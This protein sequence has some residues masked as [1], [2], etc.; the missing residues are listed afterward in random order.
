MRNEKL[1]A[2]M[3]TRGRSFLPIVC[4]I[5]LSAGLSRLS[6]GAGFDAALELSDGTTTQKSR[7]NPQSAGPTAHRVVFDGKVGAS[8]TVSWKIVRTDKTEVKDVLVHFY[9]VKLERQGESP[10]A[11]DPKIVVLESAV[12]MDF[13][14]NKVCSAKQQFKVDEPGVYLLRIEAGGD[15]DKPAAEDFVEMELVAK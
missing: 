7:S 13:P 10:P 6:L 5:L 3:R 15:P 11:L 1:D 8:F 2:P 4:F 9:I 14:Q 12:S